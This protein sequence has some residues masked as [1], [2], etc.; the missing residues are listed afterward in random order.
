MRVNSWDD[1]EWFVLGNFSTTQRNE[2]LE[3][4]GYRMQSLLAFIFSGHWHSLCIQCSRHIHKNGFT[5]TFAQKDTSL[6]FFHRWGS[7]RMSEFEAF[8]WLGVYLSKTSLEKCL[9]SILR[10][11]LLRK[12]RLMLWGMPLQITGEA[13]KTNLAAGATG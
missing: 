12:A 3:M 11:F 6:S 9:M 10:L 1:F 8:T 7:L 2:G 13:A 5:V 4:L